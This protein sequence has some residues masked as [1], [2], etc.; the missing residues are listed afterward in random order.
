MPFSLG[1]ATRTFHRLMEHV[2]K[3]VRGKFSLVYIDDVI[4]Y[5]RTLKYHEQ[6]VDV[7][8]Q[9]LSNAGL[10]LTLA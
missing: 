6:H 3:P 2:L 1:N 10:T 8:F 7:V 9:L 5:S 4:I